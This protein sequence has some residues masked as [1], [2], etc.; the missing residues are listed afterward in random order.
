[1]G[2]TQG[3]ESI[4]ITLLELSGK[5]HEVQVRST[6]TVADLKEVAVDVLFVPVEF[7]RFM[8]GTEQLHD[9]DRLISYVKNS[10]R[11][12]I[13]FIFS[14]ECLQHE[15]IA[16]RCAAVDALSRVVSHGRRRVVDVFINLATDESE[17]CRCAAVSAL[18]EVAHLADERFL[19]AISSCLLDQNKLTAVA[20]V[21]AL[22]KVVESGYSD[23]CTTMLEFLDYIED[24]PQDMMLQLAV[25]D[26]CL[27]LPPQHCL[28]VM[29]SLD[30]I[31]KSTHHDRVRC[32]ARNVGLKLRRGRKERRKTL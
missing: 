17:L 30:N 6:A 4:P 26:S 24:Q 11:L 25:I 15:S 3:F 18:G 13:S 2:M 32:A 29:R 20:A 10:E 1:M 21:K 7:Q 23:A 5:Q 27:K 31:F 22:A 16:A 12:V 8:F 9:G 28:R 14:A 19:E